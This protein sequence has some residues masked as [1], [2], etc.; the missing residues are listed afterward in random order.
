MQRG[1]N[2]HL[3]I[4]RLRDLWSNEILPGLYASSRLDRRA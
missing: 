2:S 3:P 4:L 1:G